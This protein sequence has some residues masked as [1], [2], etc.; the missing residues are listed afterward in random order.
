M[1]N[2][3]VENYFSKTAEKE[4]QAEIERMIGEH[5]AKALSHDAK[6]VEMEKEAEGLVQEL[7]RI[8]AKVDK[9][10]HDSRKRIARIEK[11]F[12]DFAK[13]VQE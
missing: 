12:V 9:D 6:L 2:S 7:R 4:R 3:K 10:I 13:L 5:T 1:L 11:N 8:T